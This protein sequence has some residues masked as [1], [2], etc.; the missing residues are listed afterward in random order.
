MDIRHLLTVEYQKIKR[1]TR[2]YV[3]F[4]RLSYDGYIFR[5]GITFICAL[6]VVLFTIALPSEEYKLTAYILA[7]LATFLTAILANGLAAVALTS[8]SAFIIAYMYYPWSLSINSIV[9]DSIVFVVLGLFMSVLLQRI[10]HYD[11]GIEFAKREKMYQHEIELLQ[12]LN[13]QA[14]KEIT[15]REEFISIASHEL[16]TPLTT[17]LLKLQV[18]LHNVRNVTLAN[19]SVQNLLD[20]LES[21]E[22]QS[23][24]LTKMINDLLNVSIIRT[25]RL[26]LQLEEC[27]LGDLVKEVVSRFKEK[28]EHEFTPLQINTSLSVIGSYDKVRLEQVISNL[29]ANA[30]KYGKGKLIKIAVNRRGNQAYIIVRDHGIGIPKEKRDK[31]FNLFDRAGLNTEFSGLGIGL[32]IT[33]QIVQAHKGRIVV[34][35]T[36]N[37]GSEFTVELPIKTTGGA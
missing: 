28:A 23:K 2:D 4:P 33:N 14:N 7:A 32:Y 26:D 29:I 5:Y 9:I 24:R 15:M 1:Q 30:M 25:G 21:A 36:V 18:A 27:D 8:S 19:F 10:K 16:K 12:Q 20:M 31:I 17:T 11:A 6:F 13:Q 3:W 22:H 34:R 37:K 35:S